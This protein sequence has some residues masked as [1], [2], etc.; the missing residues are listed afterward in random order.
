MKK[1]L[2]TAIVSILGV[3]IFGVAAPT[4]V[5]ADYV[6]TFNQESLSSRGNLVGNYADTNYYEFSP[7]KNRALAAGTDWYTN[8]FSGRSQDSFYRRVATNEWVSAMNVAYVQTNLKHTL[9]LSTSYTIFKLNPSTF[10]FEPTQNS[11]TAGS[12]SSDQIANLPSALTFY[13][14][15]SNEWIEYDKNSSDN[16]TITGTLKSDQKVYNSSSKSLTRVLPSG[17]SWKISTI[18]RNE[19]NV[20]WGKI[21]GDEWL[22]IDANSLSLSEREADSVPSLAQ[23]YPDFAIGF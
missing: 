7:V 13:R 18:V 6:H 10:K 17:S 19:N 22:K 14:V 2:N 16:S 23:S 4:N 20:F 8:G 21:S 12:W 11:L 3:A 9:N 1:V 15:A 5:K